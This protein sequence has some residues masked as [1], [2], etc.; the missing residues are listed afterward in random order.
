MEKRADVYRIQ[1]T[2]IVRPNAIKYGIV[3]DE[4]MHW[5]DDVFIGVLESNVITVTIQ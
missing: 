3:L 1:L 5:D 4:P 2:Y